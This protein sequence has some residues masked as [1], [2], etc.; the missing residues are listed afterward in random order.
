MGIDMS[1]DGDGA[2]GIVLLPMDIMAETF[3]FSST[4]I[5]TSQ[6][7]NFILIPF[8]SYQISTDSTLSRFHNSKFIYYSFL[9][10]SNTFLTY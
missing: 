4:K 10:S 8:Q 7:H 6:V 5:L 2:G 9:L 3:I 1:E